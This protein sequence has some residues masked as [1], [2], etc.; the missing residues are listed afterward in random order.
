M[1]IL[2]DGFI[3]CDVDDVIFNTSIEWVTRC[4]NAGLV[5]KPVTAKDV[6]ARP[7]YYIDKWLDMSESERTIFIDIFKN[8]QDELYDNLQLTPFGKSIYLYFAKFHKNIYFVSKVL[9]DESRSKTERLKTFFPLSNIIYVP[10]NE[11]KGKYIQ[12]HIDIN[13]VNMIIDDHLPNITDILSLMDMSKRKPT[14]KLEILA[15]ALGFVLNDH[16]NINLIKMYLDSCPLKN[17]SFA[18]YND[19]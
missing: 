3:I 9:T 16:N 19:I 18:I 12:N 6:Q 13:N 15:P 10:I 11:S 2:N 8:S 17:T 5:K 7:V 4:I 14:A 1:Q